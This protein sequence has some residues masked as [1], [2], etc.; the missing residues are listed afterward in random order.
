MDRIRETFRI[1]TCAWTVSVVSPRPLPS[2]PFTAALPT[3]VR[4]LLTVVVGQRIRTRRH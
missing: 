3:M 1:Q 4:R 2:L